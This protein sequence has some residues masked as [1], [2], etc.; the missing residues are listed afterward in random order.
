MP[1]E[2][3]SQFSDYD[4]PIG[5]FFDFPLTMTFISHRALFIFHTK[6]NYWWKREGE[7]GE[8][9]EWL[10]KKEN[11]AKTIKKTVFN[12]WSFLSERF[13]CFKFISQFK[14]DLIFHFPKQ[15]QKRE[16]FSEISNKLMLIKLLLRKF[17]WIYRNFE[18]ITD[19]KTL[20]CWE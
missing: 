7:R 11:F 6:E 16:R 13:N 4:F 1:P 14:S 9:K 15:W 10:S 8:E 20:I 2:K 18:L 3:W 5:V 17:N 12:H 19:I